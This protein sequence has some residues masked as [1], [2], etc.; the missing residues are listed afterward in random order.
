MKHYK[1]T[2]KTFYGIN[3]NG[4]LTA[5]V[6]FKPYKRVLWFFWSQLKTAEMYYDASKFVRSINVAYKS[7]EE[8]ENFIHK[9]HEIRDKVN[10]YT[11]ETVVKINL[12]D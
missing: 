10:S 5:Q 1:I 6:K 12:K 11:I 7:I 4:D 2:K 3:N 8:A 9:Y